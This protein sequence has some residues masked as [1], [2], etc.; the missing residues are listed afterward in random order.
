M[1]VADK[2]LGFNENS[3]DIIRYSWSIKIREELHKWV[4]VFVTHPYFEC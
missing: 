1:F 3:I 4:S 2:L